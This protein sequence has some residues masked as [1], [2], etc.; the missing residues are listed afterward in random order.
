MQK[1]NSRV[2]QSPLA[3]AAESLPALLMK[4]K[5]TFSV[6]GSLEGD[7]RRK[8]MSVLLHM[9]SLSSRV[10]PKLC[11]Y[12]GGLNAVASSCFSGKCAHS[13]ESLKYSLSQIR[14]ELSLEFLSY[15]S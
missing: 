5:H 14:L 2:S 7:C 8:A 1:D 9:L 11:E 15:L 13:M 10:R 4:A 3:Y 12:A 6:S